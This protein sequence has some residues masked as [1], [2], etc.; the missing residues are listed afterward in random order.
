MNLTGIV[1]L[2]QE[3]DTNIK[4]MVIK[5]TDIEMRCP[6]VMVLPVDTIE[7]EISLRE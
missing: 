5:L 1:I 3:I 2:L 7:P 6:A 4:D